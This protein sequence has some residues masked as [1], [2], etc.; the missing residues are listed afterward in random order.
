ME[1]PLKQRLIGAAV[2]IALAVIFLPMFL[3]GAGRREQLQ[4]EMKIPP[5]PKFSFKY[6][7]P[8]APEPVTHRPKATPP[9]ALAEVPREVAPSKGERPGGGAPGP[10]G[11]KARPAP[12]V[13]P[14][15]VGRGS[16]SQGTR[17]KPAREAVK[18]TTWVVQAGSFVRE[19]NAKALHR[20]LARDGFA[21]FVETYRGTGKAP[22]YRVKLGPV[23][24]RAKA[25]ALKVRLKRKEGIDGIVMGY[26]PKG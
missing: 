21:A 18:R 9:P 4:M 20:R 26:R 8:P 5:E 23:D 2:L 12:V 17:A 6:E 24:S 15:P 10:G 13:A 3:D 7:E 11:S 14:A 1:I 22:A 19:A 25:S 16:G